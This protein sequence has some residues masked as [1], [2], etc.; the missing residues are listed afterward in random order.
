MINIKE[1]N[2]EYNKLENVIKSYNEIDSDY[3]IYLLLSA[4]ILPLICIFCMLIFN[5]TIDYILFAVCLIFPSM[6][7]LPIIKGIGLID[8]YNKKIK[9]KG[10]FNSHNFPRAHFGHTGR[11]LWQLYVK[12]MA[13]GIFK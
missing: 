3:N 8:K 13:S 9:L 4:L 1:I 7:I 10:L 6:F 12:E 5:L 2:K 11:L